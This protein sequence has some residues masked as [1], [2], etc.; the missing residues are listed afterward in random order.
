MTEKCKY[1]EKY[2][3]DELGVQHTYNC[4]EQP[5]ESGYCIFHDIEYL[6]P[7]NKDIKSR[8]EKFMIEFGKKLRY[9]SEN[10]KKDW[11]FIGYNILGF[12]MKDAT[13]TQNIFFTYSRIL[14]D[15]KFRNVKFNGK[16][17]FQGAHFGGN[18][19]FTEC[20]FYIRH[21]NLKI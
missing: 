16:I 17:S 8:T 19:L 12:E 5:T 3:W 9:Y 14:G 10:K 2:Y 11:M 1:P 13:I 7:K 4:D 20:E 21:N 15:A 18:V 6:D